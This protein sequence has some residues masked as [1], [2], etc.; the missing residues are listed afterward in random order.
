MSA[1]ART[2]TTKTPVLKVI[3]WHDSTTLPSGGSRYATCSVTRGIRLGHDAPI[4][5]LLI[6]DR[7]AADRFG[8]SKIEKY[9]GFFRPRT[10]LGEHPREA[11]LLPGIGP[12]AIA[13]FRNQSELPPLRGTTL[14]TSRH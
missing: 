1:S 8:L 6:Q 3:C 12:E 9:V 10:T 7:N 13:V 5:G 14:E 11:S 4:L 2:V